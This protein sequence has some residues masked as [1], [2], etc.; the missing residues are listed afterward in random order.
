M[1]H[2]TFGWPEL[3][4]AAHQLMCDDLNMLYAMSF[5]KGDVYYLDVNYGDND[6]DGSSWDEAFAT[7][8]KALL[9]VSSGDTIVFRGKV[10][11]Q[12]TA[13]VGVFDVTIIGAGNRPR[14]ADVHASGG[15]NIAAN[16]WTFPA[17]G[18]TDSPLLTVLHQ[19]WRF[20]N[21]VFAGHATDSCIK[22]LRSGDEGTV[23]ERDASHI[24]FINC[25]FASGQDGIEQSGGCH[26][27]GIYGCT[28]EGLTGTAL[29]HTGGAGIGYPI[30]WVIKDCE[31]MSCANIMTAV[32]AA[33]Y[34]IRNNAFM[35][36]T[37]LL[38]DF[39][40]GARNVVVD[41]YFNILKADFDPTGLVTGTATDVWSN[42]LLDGREEGLPAD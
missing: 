22:L 40:G 1:R 2:S 17:S 16:T 11:E 36:T 9:S 20:V 6:N 5:P 41:N 37:T 14:H 28:F 12:L 23:L 27:I 24:E 42:I 7:M 13:P 10:R 19:G 3:G 4:G 39:T 35:T 21:I 30:R 31:F 38:F 34:L 25:R 32:A 15:G 33:D 26:H 8:A 29:K 18:S